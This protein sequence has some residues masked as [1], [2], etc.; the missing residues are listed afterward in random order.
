MTPSIFGSSSVFDSDALPGT[1]KPAAG[2]LVSCA[3][4]TFF[5]LS[6]GLGDSEVV[7]S[8]AG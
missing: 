3:N 5:W 6:S 1:L 8:A 2:G 7:L 4:V